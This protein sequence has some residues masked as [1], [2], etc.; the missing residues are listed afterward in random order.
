MS[1]DELISKVESAGF[2]V[3]IREMCILVGLKNRAVSIAEVL[4][5]LECPP[6]QIRRID[7]WVE[8]CL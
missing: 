5:L 1:P 6:S 7:G 8:I 4:P 2:M 3:K